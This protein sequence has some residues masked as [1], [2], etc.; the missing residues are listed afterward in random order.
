MEAHRI[1]ITGLLLCGIALMVGCQGLVGANTSVTVKLAG[2]GQG[3]VTSAPAGI[4]C[5]TQCTATIFTPQPLTLNAIPAAGFVFSGWSGACTGTGKCTISLSTTAAAVTATFS[6]SLKSINHI[7]FLSQENRSFD[8]YFGAMREYWA[9]NGYSDQP[10]DGL[11]QFNSPAG[12]APSNPGCN[13]AFPF[14][15]TG[16]A[17]Q[18][19]DCMFDPTNPVTS[20]HFQTMC[21]ENPSPSWNESH[22]DW[23]YNDPTGQQAAKVDGFVYSAGH[24][25]R[26]IVPPFNDTNGLRAMGYYDGNDL[27]FYYF[28]ASNFATSDR[29]FSPVMSRTPL[30]REYQIAAT[31]QGYAYPVGTNSN[32]QALITAPPI[33]E[34]LQNAGITWK[35]YVHTLPSGCTTPQCLYSQSYVQNFTYGP[36]VLNNYPQNLETT[37]QFIKDAQN[38]TLPQVA[39]IEPASANGLDEHPSDFDPTPQ[40]P[41]PCCSVQV[42]ANF[43]DSLISAVMDGPSW[44]DTIFILTYDE[45]GGFYDHVSPQPAVS[46]DGIK[47]KDLFPGDIC[48]KVTGPTCD[49]TYT[50]YR[51]PLIVISPYTKKHYVSHTV[52]DTTAILK[53]IETRFNLPSLTKRDA[54]QPDMTEFFDFVNPVWI[55]GPKLPA[56]NGGGA[57]YLDHLP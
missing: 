35:I 3:T 34:K 27:N 13:P 42:G 14:D 52:M 2:S 44:K 45:P 4:D 21:V 23:D 47:P 25:S 6:A 8:S 54:A 48:T 17:P 24:D 43:V 9:Q 51:V 15:P 7:V 50:G 29:W 53:L 16:T 32:D 22:V 37:D 20:F 55:H 49:F 26:D 41:T 57:C 38:G 30:N 36:T 19:N 40:Q 33:F 11:P 39:Q 56:Q 28:M 18:T 5:G 1:R 31:S 10:F 46:P 12:A